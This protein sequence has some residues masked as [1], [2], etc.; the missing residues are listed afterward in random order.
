M[1]NLSILCYNVGLDTRTFVSLSAAKFYKPLIFSMSGFAL[2]YNENTFILKILYDICLLRAQFCYV[3][4]QIRKVER[5]VQIADRCEPWIISIGAEN[6]SCT[7]YDFMVWLK[8]WASAANSQI[9]RISHYGSNQYFMVG[10]FNV[11]V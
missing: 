10:Q 5:R 4:V 7:R 8:V 2:S 1:S 9:E 6:L 11:R 3:V